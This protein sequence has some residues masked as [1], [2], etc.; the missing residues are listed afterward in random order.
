M[1]AST[2]PP[3]DKESGSFFLPGYRNYLV[4]CD[5]SGLHG[6][7]TTFLVVLDPGAAP[8]R[9]SPLVLVAL[10]ASRTC[11]T[12]HNPLLMRGGAASGPQGA[13]AAAV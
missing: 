1:A 6:S 11:G 9:L 4:Y 3:G 2:L 12:S 10:S 5:D 8:G 7:T 13:T